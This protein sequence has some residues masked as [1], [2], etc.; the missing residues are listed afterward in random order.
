MQQCDTLDYLKEEFRVSEG[1]QNVPICAGRLHLWH[2]CNMN[3]YLRYVTCAHTANCKLDVHESV[4][5]DVIMNTT[6]EMQL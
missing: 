6:N 1:I 2:N 5:S 4:H 3:K